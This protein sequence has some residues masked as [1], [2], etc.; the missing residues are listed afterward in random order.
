MQNLIYAVDADENCRW[1]TETHLV[2]NGG[3]YSAIPWMK[4]DLS[5]IGRMEKTVEEPD[6]PPRDYL[7][8]DMRRHITY[9]GMTD[10]Y[11]KGETRDAPVCEPIQCGHDGYLSDVD[12]ETVHPSLYPLQPCSPMAAEKIGE[13]LSELP[14]NAYLRSNEIYPFNIMQ[15]GQCFVVK[16]GSS[17][18]KRIRVI[19]SKVNAKSKKQ[20]TVIKHSEFECYEVARVK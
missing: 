13:Y 14:V 4:A 7:I 1:V 19:T 2:E 16:F 6:L 18:S 17:A 15:I 3:S 5:G 12:N 9:A 10:S 11:R 20:F 8:P